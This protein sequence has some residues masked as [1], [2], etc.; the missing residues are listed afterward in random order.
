[1]GSALPLYRGRDPTETDVVWLH[2]HLLWI[3]I[4]PARKLLQLFLSAKDD[5]TPQE[6]HARDQK[7]GEKK[8]VPPAYIYF[9]GTQQGRCNTD[10]YRF[11]TWG[12]KQNITTQDGDGQLPTAIASGGS[13]LQTSVGILPG[14]G[15][16]R[17]E[18]C[19]NY[20]SAFF[21][22]C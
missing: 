18:K 9:L 14:E 6:T 11:E 20:H 19:W 4:S 10:L 3:K 15:A 22:L 2:F 21:I 8:I 7:Q 16:Q 13:R 5:K 1:M 17:G 12:D